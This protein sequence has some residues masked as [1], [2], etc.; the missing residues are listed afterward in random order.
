VP[1]GV[2]A[3]VQEAQ[4]TELEPIRDRTA[5]ESPLGELA[6]RNHPM[7]PFRQ[8]GNIAFALLAALAIV[9]RTLLLRFG[10][11]RMYKF[12]SS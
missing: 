11:H 1:H 2:Y 9:L 8:P 6:S 3:T 12:S 10:M 4:L 7:L 5:P